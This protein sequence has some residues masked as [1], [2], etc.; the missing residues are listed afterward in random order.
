MLGGEVGHLKKRPAVCCIEDASVN[1]Q[2][3]NVGIIEVVV[4]KRKEPL[5][6][7]RVDGLDASAHLIDHSQL[8]HGLD[9][10]RISVAFGTIASERIVFGVVFDEISA[11]SEDNSVRV[12]GHRDSLFQRKILVRD[13]VVKGFHYNLLIVFR[14][15]VHIQVV[16]QHYSN[17][18]ISDFVKDMIGGQQKRRMEVL[19]VLLAAFQRPQY[20]SGAGAEAP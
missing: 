19:V 6:L 11:I 10:K 2:L 7:A 3:N 5:A 15:F 14:G 20:L 4:R 1:C 18:G 9:Q 16:V 17:S 13:A 12:L 8:N